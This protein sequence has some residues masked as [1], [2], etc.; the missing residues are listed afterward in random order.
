MPYKDLYPLYIK[1]CSTKIIQKIRVHIGKDFNGDESMKEG[2][3]TTVFIES[4]FGIADQMLVASQ[5]SGLASLLGP[6]LGIQ[7][8]NTEWDLQ[9]SYR[10]TSAAL[11]VRR[12]IPR[13]EIDRGRKK[14]LFDEGTLVSF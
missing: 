8:G 14:G 9:H 4:C 1:Y 5:G 11:E 2:W 7:S 3:A 10:E 12:E 6:L 13:K